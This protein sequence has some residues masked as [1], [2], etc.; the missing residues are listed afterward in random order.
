MREAIERAGWSLRLLP[1]YSPDLNP[2]ELAFSEL[3]SLLRRAG[4]R[5]VDGLWE[6]LGGALDAFAP[7]DCLNYTGHCGYAATDR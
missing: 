4:K 6:F 3:K 2:I 7:Q 1:P 5:T